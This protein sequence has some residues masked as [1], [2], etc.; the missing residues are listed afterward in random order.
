MPF[1]AATKRVF[2]AA[3]EYSRNMRH[4]FISPEHIAIG[5]FTVDDGSAAQ[6]SQRLGANATHLAAVAITRLQGE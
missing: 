5:L 4:K 2:E 1:S 3:V 6:V